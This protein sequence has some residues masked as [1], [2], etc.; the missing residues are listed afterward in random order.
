MSRPGTTTSRL[1]TRPARS[2]RV[3]TGPWFIVGTTGTADTLGATVGPI[4]PCTSLLDYA[5]RFGSRTA[6]I[7][8]AGGG[9][10]QSYDAAEFYFREGGTELFV[11]PATYHATPS[12]FETNIAASLLLFKKELGPGQVS[13][14][15][16]TTPATRKAV[17]DHCLAMNRIPLLDATNTATV[18][19]ITTEVG[20]TTITTPGERISGI[21]APWVT[22]PGVTPLS[23]RTLAPSAI[24]AGIIAR[25]DAAG[26]TPNQAAAGAFGESESAIEPTYAYTDDERTTLNTN[27][28]NVLRLVYGGVRVYGF[29][30]LADPSDAA[31]SNYT[32]L[33]NARLYMAIQAV[34]EAIGERF[35][36]RQ[37]DGRRLVI[38]EYGGALT[39]ALMPYYEAGALYGDTPGEAFK[40][41]VGPTVN[42]TATIAAGQLRANVRLRM[43]PFAEEVLLELVK[44]RIT[45]AV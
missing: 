13:V 12:T 11:S 14:P 9:V 25:N 42:T 40:V 4:T 43:S 23:T 37:I 1:D 17:A 2:A 24:V 16:R 36:F 33:S 10:F 7:T 15:G 6:H 27:G 41:D 8:D 22:V 5:T 30:T 21:F 29:R 44:T 32:L 35:V 34:L 31:E 19:T 18:A 28:V 3:Q 39:G 45:E 26:I 38:A 20:A